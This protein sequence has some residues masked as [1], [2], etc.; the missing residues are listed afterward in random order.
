MDWATL[1]LFELVLMRVTGFIA[2]NPLFGRNNYPNMVKAGFIMVL[3]VFVWSMADTAVT[4]PATLIEL[5]V[6]LLLEFGVGITLAF[7]MRVFFTVVQVG[8]EVLDAQ[9]GLNMAQVYDAS[10]QINMTVTASLL[11]VLMV[12]TFFAENGHYTLLRI[13]LSSGEVVPYGTATLGQAVASGVAEVFFSCM[14]LSLK[15]A[16]P[17]LA[18]ELLGELGMGIL[19]KAIPQI[20]AFVINIELKVIIGLLLLFVFLT[21]INEFLLEVEGDMLT[22]LGRIL[23]IISASG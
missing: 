19:M 23:E 21:P 2:A 20:N 12:L 14:V 4:P 15:L 17:I 7:V 5:V 6:R 22:A 13:F 9:M 10:S 18:A 1:Y 3:S 11:N 16:F 8:G